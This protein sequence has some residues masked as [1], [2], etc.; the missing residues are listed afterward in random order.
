MR[1]LALLTTT[2]L[3]STACGPT[4][5]SSCRRFY[6]QEACNAGPEGL[7][8]EDAIAQ[9]TDICHSALQLTGPEPAA[10][11][12]RFNPEFI[13]PAT[14]QTTLANEREAAA[15]MDCVWSFSDDECGD[16]LGDR[17]CALIF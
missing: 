5:A 17:Y 1:A 12:R 9:C 4:C 11:D 16:R 10:D 6:D 14:Q 2:A 3:L 7:A 8:T 15:W 13:A